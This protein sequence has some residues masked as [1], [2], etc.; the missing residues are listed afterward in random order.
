MG[1]AEKGV[2]AISPTLALFTGPRSKQ[3]ND[4]I[5]SSIARL[6]LGSTRQDYHEGGGLW[7]AKG[8]RNRTRE[9]SCTG[10]LPCRVA[11]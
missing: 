7:G 2:F 11:A 1:K 5:Y 10:L 3:L 6:P 4:K 9:V 8:P